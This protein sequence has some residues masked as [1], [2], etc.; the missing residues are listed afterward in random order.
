MA[1]SRGNRT[2]L[3]A[4]VVVTALVL[5]GCGRRGPL[6]PPSAAIGHNAGHGAPG[7][8]QSDGAGKHK[9]H[10]LDFLIL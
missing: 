10:P 8:E 7:V 4:G 6:E 9:P 2:L 1:A 3:I 5:S